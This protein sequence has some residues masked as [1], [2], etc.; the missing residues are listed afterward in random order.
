MQGRIKRLDVIEELKD[1]PDYAVDTEGNVWSFK[2]KRQ[3]KLSPGWKR[4]KYPYLF[5]RLSD[6]YGNKKNF[7][8][9]RLVALAFIPTD[10]TSLQVNHKNRNGCDN[11]LENLEWVTHKENM[12][13]YSDSIKSN[14]VK[15]DDFLVS[16]LKDVH[17]AS[18][19]KGLPVPDVYSFTNSIIESA[20]EDY[21]NQYGLRKVM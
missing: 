17:V 7:N 11:K 4:K 9:H 14:L 6:R 16:K 18:I 13:H 3:H 12:Q 1:Y 15:V 20:L 19:R 10:D 2:Y 21:I 8:V 5:V